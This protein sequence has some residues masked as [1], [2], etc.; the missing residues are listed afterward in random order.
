MKDLMDY[1]SAPTTFRVV[2]KFSIVLA[3]IVILILAAGILG[4]N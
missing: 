4:G 3:H 1:L 2:D